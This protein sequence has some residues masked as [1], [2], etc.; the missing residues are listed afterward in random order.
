MTTEEKLIDIAEKIFNKDENNNFPIEYEY[1]SLDVKMLSKCLDTNNPTDMLHDIIYDEYYDYFL[2]DD[3]YYNCLREKA[4]ASISDESIYEFIN[5]HFQIV[6]DM[7]KILSEK[8]AVNIML[9][10]GN[11]NYDFYSDNVLNYASLYESEQ[12]FRPESSVKWLAKQFS[13]FDELNGCVTD[14]DNYDN[15]DHDTFINSV[16]EELENNSCCNSG[17]VFLSYMT[18]SDIITLKTAVKNKDADSYITLPKNTMTGLF[19]FISGG[20]SALDIALPDNIKI[21]CDKI[22]DIWLSGYNPHGYDIDSVYG[23]DESA[24]IDAEPV[25]LYV[26]NDT[27]STEEKT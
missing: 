16:I 27:K 9:D 11:A 23:L 26:P 19:D 2:M 6:I 18:L 15:T 13:K 4:D 25:E 7:E 8:Y 17:I 24:W 22:F 10:T 21:P 5:E 3:Y 20:G 1:D 12:K 14:Y